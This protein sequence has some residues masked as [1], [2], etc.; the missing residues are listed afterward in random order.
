MLSTWEVIKGQK[1]RVKRAFRA[2]DNPTHAFADYAQN[3]ASK[4]NYK[5]AFN[6]IEQPEMFLKEVV[7][8]GYATDPNYYK[9]V[10]SV[11]KMIKK[12]VI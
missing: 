11:M 8:G 1:V 7:K 5:A 9:S 4:E 12:Y 6:Y 10:I 3:L 2:Y